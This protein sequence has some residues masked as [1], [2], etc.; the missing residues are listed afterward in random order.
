MSRVPGY[1]AP[2]GVSDILSALKL[3]PSSGSGQEVILGPEAGV[4]KE[5]KIDLQPVVKTKS[6]PAVVAGQRSKP[7]SQG[8]VISKTVFCGITLNIHI[9]M[10]RR[11]LK[12][13]I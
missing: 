9:F 4:R 2:E 10:I 13:V 5:S 6:T 3:R 11:F 8:V 1:G 12:T 7:G